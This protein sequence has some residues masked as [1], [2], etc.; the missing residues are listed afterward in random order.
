M[1]SEA[2][3]GRVKIQTQRTKIR[4]LVDSLKLCSHLHYRWSNSTVKRNF[5]PGVFFCSYLHSHWF[6]STFNLT[7]LQKIVFFVDLTSQ[8]SNKSYQVRPFSLSAL[9]ILLLFSF[10]FG[11][12]SQI[13]VK[14]PKSERPIIFFSSTHAHRLFMDPYMSF[15]PPI[16]NRVN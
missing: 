4:I 15:V 5:I 2:F 7:K 6:N 16:Y 1:L 11:L 3:T 8:L 10:A 13:Y 9:K 14:M 12:T